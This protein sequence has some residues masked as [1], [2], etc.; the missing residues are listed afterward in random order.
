MTSNATCQAAPWNMI[1]NDEFNGTALDATKWYPEIGATGWGN[2]ELQYYS[3]TSNNIQFGN[4]QLHMVARNDGTA[5]QQY[6]SA[7]LITKN[8]FSFFTS[9]C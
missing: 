2:N 7:R 6:S 5:G 4:G 9:T 8:L 1:W 3:G